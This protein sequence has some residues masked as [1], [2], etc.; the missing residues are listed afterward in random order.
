MN[1][2]TALTGVSTPSP[3]ST[4]AKH[5]RQ[6]GGRLPRFRSRSAGL[7]PD[8]LLDD[9]GE[10]V[11]G[12]ALVV[13]AVLEHGAERGRHRLLVE[14]ADAETAEG[15]GPVDRLGDA[16]RLVQVERA[17]RL[18]GGGDL[19]GQRAR[20]RPGSRRWTIATSRSNVG[21]STQW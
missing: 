16:G 21:C 13:L 8:G 2:T 1:D 6:L 18:D 17:Q 9:V 12:D 19:A 4:L 3:R 7:A 10:A 11:L 14:L 5:D 15:G 20:R